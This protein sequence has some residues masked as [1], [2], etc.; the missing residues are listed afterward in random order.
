MRHL[1]ELFHGAPQPG[2]RIP[3]DLVAALDD[4]A[5]LRDIDK[6]HLPD[7]G[8]QLEVLLPPKRG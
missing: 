5:Q 8:L 1:A 3:L 6:V 2:D 7:F 4:H